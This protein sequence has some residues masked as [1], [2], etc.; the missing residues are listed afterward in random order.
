[1]V[2]KVEVVTAVAV[3]DGTVVAVKVAVPV[4]SV[5]LPEVSQCYSAMHNMFPTLQA[6]MMVM[7]ELVLLVLLR[8]HQQ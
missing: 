5:A 8:Q 2:L 7:L 6:I 3:A 1:M 4:I